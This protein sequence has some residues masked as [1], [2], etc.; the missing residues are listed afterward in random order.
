MTDLWVFAAVC[1][2]GGLGA[3]LRYAVDA[4]VTPRL[5]V[6][7]PVATMLINVS[8][9]LALGLL[10]GAAAATGLPTVWLLV[11]GGGLLGGY[12]TFSTASVETVRLLR[13]KRYLAAAANG[14]GMAVVAIAAAAL[15][16]ALGSA[17]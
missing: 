11:A 1:V 13:A 9:S 8:G 7:F 3:A 17:L 2:A 4:A 5:R 10:T 16:V 14:P 12:T 15:G 6:S